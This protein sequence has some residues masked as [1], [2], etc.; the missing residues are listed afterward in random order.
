MVAQTTLIQQPAL[1]FSLKLSPASLAALY[2]RSVAR[3]LREALGLLLGV[4]AE[5]V[6]IT[7]ILDP[8]T[9]KLTEITSTDAINTMGNIASTDDVAN[10]LAKGGDGSAALSGIKSSSSSSGSN[11]QQRMALRRVA[12][13]GIGGGLSPGRTANTSATD[14]SVAFLAYAR[15]P[16]AAV[17]GTDTTATLENALAMKGILDDASAGGGVGLYE[18]LAL[19]LDSLA[20]AQGLPPGSVGAVPAAGTS[21]TA[22]LVTRT[23]T[24]WSLRAWLLWAAS[25]PLGAILGGTLSFLVLCIVFIIY[26]CHRK[27]GSLQKAKVVPLLDTT[28]VVDMRHSPR[29]RNHDDEY[30]KDSVSYINDD[31]S[32]VRYDNDNDDD[33]DDIGGPH[34]VRVSHHPNSQHRSLPSAKHTV[35]ARDIHRKKPSSSSSFS[36][37][38]ISDS[39]L[40]DTT[41]NDNSTTD[42]DNED[43][44]SHGRFSHSHSSRQKVKE[45]A[46]QP[47]GRRQRQ[48]ISSRA[49]PPSLSFPNATEGGGSVSRRMPVG[50]KAA[51]A[52]ASRV[53]PAVQQR[54]IFAARAAAALDPLLL[55]QH[56]IEGRGVAPLRNGGGALLPGRLA[57]IGPT[58]R[59]DGDSNSHRGPISPRLLGAGSAAIANGTDG[60]IRG[61]NM[62]AAAHL[63]QQQAMILSRLSL[64]SQEDGEGGTS[65]RSRRSFEH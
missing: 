31:N 1:L 45:T 53:T 55:S 30:A 39:D 32:D 25:L 23:Q 33:D 48:S 21:S 65:S 58:R 46:T 52:A 4:P 34:S 50:T 26:R 7:G 18:S 37:D 11:N 13:A 17:D 56:H 28:T 49:P 9:N 10:E 5:V 51:A 24:D 64:A 15:V 6:M 14:L 41:D 54:R 2:T 38:D 8:R 22:T 16:Y 27:R 3:A 61:L 42:T 36:S 62:N 29:S 44:F 20:D 40:S 12:T 43:R 63:E 47:Y 57:P 60:G 19:G 35:A 59:G